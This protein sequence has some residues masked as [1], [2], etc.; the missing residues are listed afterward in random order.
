MIILTSGVMASLVTALFSKMS[1]DKNIRITN[2]TKE[3]KQW[4]EFIRQL[5]RDANDAFHGQDSRKIRIVEAEL[6]VRL[7]PR[8]MNDQAIIKVLHGLP[9]WDE[10]KLLEFNVRVSLLLKHDWERVKNEATITMSPQ[11]IAIT[12]TA[13]TLILAFVVWLVHSQLLGNNAAVAVVLLGLSLVLVYLVGSFINYSLNE[14]CDSKRKGLSGE[15]DDAAPK[16]G[17]WF[18][19]KPVRHSYHESDWHDYVIRDGSGGELGMTGHIMGKDKNEILNGLVGTAEPGSP[20]HEQQKMGIIVR[21]TEDLE[22]AL[23][24]DCRNLQSYIQGG[25]Y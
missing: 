5:V 1:A 12:T 2:I 24:N 4:R 11:T 3:R 8:D 13:A 22:K 16:C 17:V 6:V 21:C 10:K 25:L 7:N 20:V 19:C 15:G 14:R 23:G 18:Q 9:S